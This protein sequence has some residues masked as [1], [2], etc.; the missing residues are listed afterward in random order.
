MT[1][2]RDY[3]AHRHGEPRPQEDIEALRGIVVAEFT[4][5]ERDGL[6]QWHLGYDC[7]DAG[8]VAG[9]SA[10]ADPRA[11]TRWELG[12]DLW[13]L[14][15]H[16]YSLDEGWVF[17]VLEFLWRH[18]ATPTKSRIHTYADCGIHVVDADEADGRDEFRQSINRY[19]PR[20][21]SGFKMQATG[22]IWSASPTGL[23]YLRPRQTGRHEI[24]ARVN[25]AIHTFRRYSASDEDK[26][27]AIKNLA[28]ILEHLREEG[29]TG[30]PKNDEKRLFEIANQFSI[31]HHNPSQKTD[32]DTGVWLNWIYYSFL[33]SVS[34]MSELIAR[35]NQ[36]STGTDELID[37]PFE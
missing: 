4:R 34:L 12:R 9:R 33:N 5:L 23:E 10:G 25:H 32:Y 21:G 2:A 15:D 26:R 27:D 18:A 30:L 28:D 16:L 17:S 36:T 31:R 22:E 8:I 19:L 20:Y 11:Y 35:L 13:P 3:Y 37:L 1:D 24:D 7:V 6:F 29:G 14:T